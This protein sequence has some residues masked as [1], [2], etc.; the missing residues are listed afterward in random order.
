MTRAYGGAAE[1]SG[2]HSA[3]G[4]SCQSP[5]V[6]LLDAQFHRIVSHLSVD[7]KPTPGWLARLSASSS[8]AWFPRALFRTGL[9]FHGLRWNQVRS[10][11]LCD[12]SKGNSSA[13]LATNRIHK[14]VLQHS[15]PALRFRLRQTR[16]SVNRTLR[17][18]SVQVGPQM[19][20]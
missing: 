12:L 5:E 14:A 10:R 1:D 16:A 3:L 20:K 7:V 18:W 11:S 9:C 15:F 6:H 17:T 4:N 19:M 13:N 2:Q 8:E